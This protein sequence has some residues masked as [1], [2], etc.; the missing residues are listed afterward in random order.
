MARFVEKAIFGSRVLVGA[1]SHHFGGSLGE[2]TFFASYTKC[3]GGSHIFICRSHVSPR[4]GNSWQKGNASLQEYVLRV[5]L[6]V[7][8]A[9]DN[10]WGSLRSPPALEGWLVY[11]HWTTRGA[12]FARRLRSK[13]VGMCAF[14]YVWG[15]LR[16][17]P[18]LEGSLVCVRLTCLEP[19]KI[20]KK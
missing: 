14:D 17:Q 15:S 18:A 2:K 6:H 3:V 1:T 16:S 5:R 19:K 4:S 7:G 13:V 20:K 9:S 8:L 10:G 12:R 11:V